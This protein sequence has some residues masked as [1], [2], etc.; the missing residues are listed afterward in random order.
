M[1]SNYFMDGSSGIKVENM[2]FCFMLGKVANPVETLLCAS[3]N[4]SY[5]NKCV[6]I[7]IFSIL[8]WDFFKPKLQMN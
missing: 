4:L 1:C 5:H 2:C 7:L 6:E 8:I 3:Q